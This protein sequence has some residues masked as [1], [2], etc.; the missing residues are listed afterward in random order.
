[1]LYRCEMAGPSEGSN[2]Q[3]DD[4]SK[5]YE[6]VE[7]L[8][9]TGE[10]KLDEK[11][12]KS[13]KSLCKKSDENLTN[14]Y[15]IIFNQM[16]KDHAEIRLSCFQIID[17]LFLRSH[18]FRQMILN[19]F[20]SLLEL[21]V[22]TNDER[23]LPPPKSAAKVLKSTAL[24]NIE[25][26]NQKFGKHYKKLEIGYDFLKRVKRIDFAGMR[27]S[28]L[29]ER[30]RQKSLE[31]R[32]RDLE[33]RTIEKIK[34]EMQESCMDI[35]STI[36]QGNS[37]LHLVLP[38]PCDLYTDENSELR[39]EASQDT[40]FDSVRG[41][42]TASSSNLDNLEEPNTHIIGKYHGI[43]TKD[44]KITIK[45][46]LGKTVVVESDDNKDI[47]A[48]LHDLMNE[49]RN[50]FVPM[51]NRWINILTKCNNVNDE[52]AK[53]M[54][55]KDSLKELTEKYN[56]IQIDRHKSTSGGSKD[57]DEDNNNGDDDTDMFE[58]VPE[59][60]GRPITLHH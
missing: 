59:A 20:H 49:I 56:D 26:W 37:C 7:E 30:Q 9:T 36:L 50:K 12:M 23:K 10:S 21:C 40:K 28:T 58:D 13:L 29:L 48:N 6:L 24:S 8:T 19:D 51:V 55:F 34:Q 44:Y 15:H 53:C 38:R 2:I 4:K 45:I 5:L 46:S 57:N 1:M 16:E 39:D 32:Q 54:R 22:E 41:E 33:K 17:E 60:E 14:V 31:T 35:E 11:S 47:L 27:S 3:I 42:T 43:P 52:L 18:A 25:N